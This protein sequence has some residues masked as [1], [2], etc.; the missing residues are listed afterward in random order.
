[1]FPN[2][3][4]DGA[5]AA[6]A[7]IL[8]TQETSERVADNLVIFKSFEEQLGCSNFLFFE[9]IFFVALYSFS[10]FKACSILERGITKTNKR[11]NRGLIAA[12]NMTL[13]G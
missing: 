5:S 7:A 8:A 13:S 12:L 1:M 4:V 3:L 6:A 11:K 9:W 2:A 10:K